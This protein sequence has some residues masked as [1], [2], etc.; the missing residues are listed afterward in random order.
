M[1]RVTEWRASRAI[2]RQ[3]R[4]ANS[5]VIGYFCVSGENRTT[6]RGGGVRESVA[7]YCSDVSVEHTTTKSPRLLSCEKGVSYAKNKS[8]ELRERNRARCNINP[9]WDVRCDLMSRARADRPPDRASSAR[10]SNDIRAE[11]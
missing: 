9:A 11:L 8:A 1:H 2:E 5:I 10:E 6:R 7:K 4:V 3:T